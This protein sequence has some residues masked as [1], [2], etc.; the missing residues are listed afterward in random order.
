MIIRA[1]LLT[2][3][4][5]PGLGWAGLQPEYAPWAAALSALHRMQVLLETASVSAP[6]MWGPCSMRLAQF[7]RDRLVGK[8]R[9]RTALHRSK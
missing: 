2:H 9:M 7:V 4:I 5:V 6:K 1:D 3:C 8:S